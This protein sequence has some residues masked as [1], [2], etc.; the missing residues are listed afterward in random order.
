MQ[1][2]RDAATGKLALKDQCT[3]EEE[4][5]GELKPYL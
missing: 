3:R 5:K 1:V 2:Y 4:A